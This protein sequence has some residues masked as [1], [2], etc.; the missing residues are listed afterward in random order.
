LDIDIIDLQSALQIDA[1]RS[2]AMTLT[3]QPLNG[4]TPMRINHQLVFGS[5]GLESSINVSMHNFNILHSPGK[6]R[7]SWGQLIHSTQFNSWLALA[8]DGE[9]DSDVEVKIFS[10]S[11]FVTSFPMSVQQGTCSQFLL[12]DVLGPATDHEEFVWYEI[13]SPNFFLTAWTIAQH[14]TSAH[15]NGEHSF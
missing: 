2:V 5:S 8:N 7:T 3:A 6:P 1:D 13:E 10:E 14:K 12:S 9:M 4:N 15:C 11:G